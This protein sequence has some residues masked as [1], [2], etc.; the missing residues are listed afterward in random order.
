MMWLSIVAK[1]WEEHVDHLKEVFGRLN[2]AGLTLKVAK[3]Q[4]GCKE[5]RY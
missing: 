3:C 2:E 4:F 1:S 5:V